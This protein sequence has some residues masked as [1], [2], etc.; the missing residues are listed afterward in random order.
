M[1]RRRSSCRTIRCGSCTAATAAFPSRAWHPAVAGVEN[2]ITS[3]EPTARS[4]TAVPLRSMRMVDTG[5]LRRFAGSTSVVLGDAARLGRHRLWDDL[6]AY[7]PQKPLGPAGGEV[8]RDDDLYTRGT[9][10][11]Y[12]SQVLPDTPFTRQM[13][14]RLRPVLARFLPINVRA[15][16]ILAPRL[17]IEYVYGQASRS[18]KPIGPSSS[19][20]ILRAWERTRTR[21]AQGRLA[22]FARQYRRSGIGRSR[23]PDEFTA[24]RVLSRSTVGR[25]KHSGETYVEYRCSRG[26]FAG[27]VP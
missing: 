16:V 13:V 7:T 4:L 5:T 6:L 9:V 23:Q 18:E 1:P 15:V 21:R 22:N 12:L 27:D 10:G 11:L 14:E 26:K 20:R 17:D 25:R 8:L 2:R 24:A 3:Q 19:H